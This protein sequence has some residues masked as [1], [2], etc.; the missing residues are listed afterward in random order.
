[1]N[2]RLLVYW[3]G[4]FFRASFPF[5]SLHGDMVYWEHGTF[6]MFIHVLYMCM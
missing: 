5:A 1:M 2:N 6:C 4:G 3:S